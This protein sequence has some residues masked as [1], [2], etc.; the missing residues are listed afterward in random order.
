MIRRPPRSTL[1]SSS[2][3]SDVYKRQAGCVC[4]ADRLRQDRRVAGLLDVRA[5]RDDEP[6]MV[7]VEVAADLGVSLPRQRLVLVEAGAVGEL[8]PGEVEDPLPCAVGDQV[9]EAEYVLVR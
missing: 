1:S 4:I 8:R 9:H 2:A 3:A 7:V 6:E 5:G